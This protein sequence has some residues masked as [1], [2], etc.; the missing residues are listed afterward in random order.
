MIKQLLLINKT[1]VKT[2][3]KFINLKLSSFEINFDVQVIEM[4]FSI[5]V[6]TSNFQQIKL[7][8]NKF[9]TRKIM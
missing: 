4:L 9:K 6:K 1:F 3:L 2:T 5:V 7:L 8:K